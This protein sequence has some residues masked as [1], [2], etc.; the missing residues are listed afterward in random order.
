MEKL[1]HNSLNPFG[2]GDADTEDEENISSEPKENPVIVPLSHKPPADQVS[3][4]WAALERA[5]NNTTQLTNPFL[6][7]EFREHLTTIEKLIAK[8]SPEANG[9]T[10]DCLEVVLSENVIESIYL[11]STRQREYGRDI[12]IMLLKFFN[13]VLTRSSQP[14]LIHQQ[15]L[16]PL[17][18]LLR[19]CEGT[20]DRDI[21]LALVPLLHQICILIQENQSFLD[22]FYVET[23]AHHPSSFLLFTQLIPHLHDMTEVG[24]RSRDALL[25]CLSLAD[26]LPHTNLSRFIATDCNF[27][28]VGPWQI[29]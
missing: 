28:Q 6:L 21:S 26:Q 25:L 17:N 19:S 16:R 11:F 27:C 1:T 10:G 2:Q 5:I 9:C 14:V 20:K 15:V 12:R 4:H 29:E 13:E 23:K 8:E 7:E 18:R 3:H 24:N 22:L